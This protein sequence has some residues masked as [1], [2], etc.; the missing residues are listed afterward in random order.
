[1]GLLLLNMALE[2]G[3]TI[4]KSLVK[5][6]P[7]YS[8]CIQSHTS[9]TKYNDKDIFLLFFIPTS[10]ESSKTFFRKLEYKYHMQVLGWKAAEVTDTLAAGRDILPLFVHSICL[11]FVRTLML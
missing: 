2:N 5:Q 10:T 6:T 11:Q 4:K 9:S 1:M 3:L 8:V 7:L